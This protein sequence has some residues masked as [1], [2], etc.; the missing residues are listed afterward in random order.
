MT[1]KEKKSGLN[2]PSFLGEGMSRPGKMQIQR[3]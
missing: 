1:E 3:R 2:A